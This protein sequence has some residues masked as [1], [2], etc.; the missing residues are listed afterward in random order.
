MFGHDS[1]FSAQHNLK[2]SSWDALFGFLLFSAFAD[3]CRLPL[4]SPRQILK[5]R[6]EESRNK[7]QVVSSRACL[8][9]WS[10][11]RILCE[12]STVSVSKRFLN[13]PCR[14][15]LLNT[16]DS[17]DAAHRLP[18]WSSCDSWAMC[19]SKCPKWN[20]FYSLAGKKAFPTES[21]VGRCRGFK[22]GASVPFCPLK[23]KT[24]GW[25]TPCRNKEPSGNDPEDSWR[26]HEGKERHSITHS[27]TF[28]CFLT[29]TQRS[30]CLHWSRW[31][32][33]EP[34]T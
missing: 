25:A 16:F 24:L 12:T 17:P 29:S 14:K 13:S 22:T 10:Y 9:S 7:L 2:P 30:I 8:G 34:K 23:L 27:I 18:V 20:E 4:K 21:V 33:I 19:I 26:K 5:S 11:Q 1:S 3:L 32:L 6:K 28:L 31:G 15:Q